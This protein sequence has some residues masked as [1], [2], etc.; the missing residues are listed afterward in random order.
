MIMEL[1]DSISS[2][3]SYIDSA[4]KTTQS[5]VALI[6]GITATKNSMD[7]LKEVFIGSH[8]INTQTTTVQELLKN[9]NHYN[10][11][12]SIFTDTK[13]INGILVPLMGFK[14]EE[15]EN[16]KNVSSSIAKEVLNL[17]IKSIENQ[18]LSINSKEWL[19]YG[20]SIQSTTTQD[21][22]QLLSLVEE[23]EANRI[24][25]LISKNLYKKK[26]DYPD[27]M[28]GVNASLTGLLVSVDNVIISTLIGHER[29]NKLKISGYQQIL[30]PDEE[31]IKD[32]GVDFSFT[33]NIGF[34]T[35]RCF[36][37]GYLWI[38]YMDIHSGTIIPIYEYGNIG[39]KNSFI[40]LSEKL[41]HQ[42]EFF[43]KRVWNELD[44][45][46]EDRR[47]KLLVAY[48]DSLFERVQSVF[49]EESYFES[50]DNILCTSREDIINNLF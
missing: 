8:K 5:I 21:R 18:F 14:G 24:P 27:L 16:Y 2:A 22:I 50:R 23:E 13:N 46:A 40:L 30:V 42:I 41:I 34:N 10:N 28:Y 43:K 11:K 25:V 19:S 1:Q 7:K 36:F 4:T 15:E 32:L 29:A 39:E 26:L 12:K 33:P 48:N 49:Q 9:H 38:L 3:T 37:L 17:K 6:S 35:E 20:C 47:Y 31:I 45:P 44:T